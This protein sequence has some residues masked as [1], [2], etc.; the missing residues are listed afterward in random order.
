M[1]YAIG[2][3]TLFGNQGVFTTGF[4]GWLPFGTP[5]GIYGPVGIVLALVVYTLPQT[6]LILAVGLSSADQRLYDAAQTLGAGA[7]RCF[8]TVT[9]PGIK[10]S[11]ISAAFVSFTLA[12][13]DFGAPKIIGGNFNVLSTDVYKQVIGQQN[14]SMGAAVAMILLAPAFL[15]FIVDRFIY[16]RRHTI[17]ANA[18]RYTGRQSRLRDAL[19]FTFCVMVTAAVLLLVLSVAAAA[20]VRSWPY[21]LS[22][23]TNHFHFRESGG[24]FTL[25]GNSVLVSAMTALGGTAV[26]V[27]AAYLIE[28][29]PFWSV[30]RQ[31]ARL[32]C[33]LPLAMP[34][35]VIGLAFI[36]FFNRGSFALPGGG[37]IPNPVHGLYNTLWLLA[38]ANI[39]HFLPVPFLTISGAF[40]KLDPD[41]E[42]AAETMGRP[43]YDLFF[44][45]SLPLSLPAVI[46]AAL[47]FFVNSMVTV[48]AVI[49]L[50]PSYFKL[51]A[52]AIVHMEEAGDI[53]PAAAMSI[54]VLGTNLI[55]RAVYEI[56]G[57]IIPARFSTHQ[58]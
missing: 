56:F 34:G 2:L 18:R 31:A 33:V 20:F 48:S 14:M 55:L 5:T 52:V 58:P 22:M 54:L 26:A 30:L 44:K 35:L 36:F 23:T 51:A 4:F 57:R 41:F 49:F 19:F 6:Y 38:I 25:L 9:L 50:Y 24:A 32:L 29:S 7:L 47:Y 40:R 13:T 27:A 8:L 17:S 39:V 21:D 11:L 1:M 15:A 42:S 28:K 45:V 12:F 37:S 16:R 43:F 10:Y 3:I 46:E 53:A